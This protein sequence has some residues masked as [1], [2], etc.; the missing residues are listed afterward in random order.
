MLIFSVVFQI[1][2]ISTL[3]TIYLYNP[4]VN[5]I[6]YCGFELCL[7]MIDDVFES[8]CYTCYSAIGIG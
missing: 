4:C 3:E 5:Y 6:V 2:R 1:I 8:T 7:V